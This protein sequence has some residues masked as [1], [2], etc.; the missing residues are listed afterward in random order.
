MASPLSYHLSRYSSWTCAPQVCW[1]TCSGSSP[2]TWSRRLAA[3]TPPAV[4]RWRPC[5][6]SCATF[7]SC[8][9][10]TGPVMTPI[11]FSTVGTHTKAPG[12]GLW[13]VRAP[14]ILLF[15]YLLWKW[16]VLSWSP[17][18]HFI[19]VDVL[20]MQ[21]WNLSFSC[22]FHDDIFHL[23]AILPCAYHSSHS[24]AILFI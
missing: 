23:T 14:H 21:S 1:T 5:R 20:G 22:L 4:L 7:W 16:S 12:L 19:S 9:Q 13:Q 18:Y 2:T 17:S 10:K 11:W 8:V 24:E 6:Q 15:L 3:T